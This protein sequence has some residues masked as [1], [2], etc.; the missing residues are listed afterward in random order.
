MTTIEGSSR[1][2]TKKVARR[3]FRLSSQDDDL[4]VEAAGLAGVSVTEFVVERAVADAEQLVA[5]HH[6]IELRADIYKRFMAALDAPV[7]HDSPF[8]NA[9]R[10]SRRIK[11]VE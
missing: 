11:T 7:Q 4:I 9:V 1:P 6:T 8:V 3:E 10:Q 2:R 5:A